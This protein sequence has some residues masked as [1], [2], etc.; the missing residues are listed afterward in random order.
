MKQG[1]TLIELLIVMVIVGILA[2]VSL[3]KYYASME[4]G[5][6]TEGIANLRAASDIINA[7][8]VINGNSYTHVGVATATSNGSFVAGDFTKN[9]YFTAPKLTLIPGTSGSATIT[10]SRT[11][12]SY[13]LKAYNSGGDLQYIECSGDTA[14]CQ[15][16]G[17]ELSNGKYQMKFN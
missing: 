16:I 4:R 8:Y 5:R 11:D 17:M 14:L 13:T 10:L 3:P 9:Q 2:T 1:F 6:A 15:N 12:G 7:R